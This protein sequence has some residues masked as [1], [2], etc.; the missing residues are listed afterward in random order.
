MACSALLLFKRQDVEGCWSDGCRRWSGCA[1]A[2]HRLY[3]DVFVSERYSCFILPGGFDFD[4]VRCGE[5]LSVQAEGFSLKDAIDEI[6]SLL[7]L[8]LIGP[9][10]DLTGVELQRQ[11][12]SES[13]QRTDSLFDP[14]IP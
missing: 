2:C 14:L 6:N 10:D 13:C 11:P 3:S 7:G 9:L 5:E 4:F 8:L 1:P 12:A